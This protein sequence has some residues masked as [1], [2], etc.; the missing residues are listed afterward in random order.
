MAI[1]KEKKKEVVQQTQDMLK[2]SSIVVF[3]DISGM[4]VP[5]LTQLRRSIRDAGGKY[6]IIKKTLLAIALQ[7]EK[8][9]KIDAKEMQGEIAVAFGLDGDITS[10]A[11]AIYTHNKENEKPIIINGIMDGDVLEIAQVNH[12]ATLPSKEE[13]LARTVGSI[14][15]PISGFVNVCNG[16]VANIVY[17]LSAIG[18]QKS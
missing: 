11:K 13:L 6:T 15:A 9:E 10:V 14:N 3:T 17:V 2:Q 4:D 16:A 5:S 12:L 8:M 18:K 7:A 1:T